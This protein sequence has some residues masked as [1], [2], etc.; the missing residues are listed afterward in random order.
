[1]R[2]LRSQPRFGGAES[3]PVSGENR[4]NVGQ[5]GSLRTGWRTTQSSRFAPAETL[6]GQVA[7]FPRLFRTDQRLCGLG[8]TRTARAGALSCPRVSRPP[9]QW[10]ELA[11]CCPAASSRAEPRSGGS[12]S[13]WSR[14]ARP[15]I[16][17][18]RPAR[19][20]PQPDAHSWPSCWLDLAGSG[21]SAFVRL[22]SHAKLWP[23]SRG[24]VRIRRDV[25]T[26]ACR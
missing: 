2:L 5:T 22:P 9:L 6:V 10:P 18:S 8:L 4:E 14:P 12:F 1:M 13:C 19:G 3:F 7:L 21:T 25:S 11:D 23:P 15:T 17:H 24:S 16:G 26:A 20:C